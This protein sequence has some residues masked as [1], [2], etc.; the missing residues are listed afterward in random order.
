MEQP[1]ALAGETVPPAFDVER[2]S[3]FQID[4]VRC[5]P[6]GYRPRLTATICSTPLA[7]MD[8][9]DCGPRG[10]LRDPGLCC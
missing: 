2:R 9:A 6:T 1:F 5:I 4:S 7:L 3:I 10:A 8:R